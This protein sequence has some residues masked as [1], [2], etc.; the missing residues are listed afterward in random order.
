MTD[1]ADVALALKARLDTVPDVGNTYAIERF[2]TDWPTYLEQF[3]AT[4][5]GVAEIRGW[6]ITLESIGANADVFGGIQRT[7]VW[8]IRG[9]LGLQDSAETEATFIALVE[10]V[11]DAID[12]QKDFGIAN[13]GDYS[14]GPCIARLI[15]VRQFGSV[16]AHYCEIQV[17]VEIERAISY[18]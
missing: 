5:G 13:V 3:K 4:V 16:L 2:I 6:T 11:M 9:M 1:Y 8:V 7:Q 17:N 15:Q 18:A 12:T 10:A 14:I